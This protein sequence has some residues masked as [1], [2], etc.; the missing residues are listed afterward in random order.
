MKLSDFEQ[1][2]DPVIVERGKDYL[3]KGRVTT[4]EES[5]QYERK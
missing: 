5:L 1:M 2:V 4:A 3:D